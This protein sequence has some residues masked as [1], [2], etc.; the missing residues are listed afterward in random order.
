LLSV[1]AHGILDA[2]L[3]WNAAEGGWQVSAGLT[4]ATN[5]SYFYDMFNLA[6]FGFGTVTG[7]P[8]PPREWTITLRKAF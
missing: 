1:P 8:A 5:Y 4:N 6:A 2:R 3:T 7:N